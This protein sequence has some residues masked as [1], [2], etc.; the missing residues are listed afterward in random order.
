MRFHYIT[1]LLVAM[2]MLFRRELLGAVQEMLLYPA[3]KISN[4]HLPIRSLL[5]QSLKK[6]ALMAI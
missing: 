5:K 2:P 4:I 6:L 3:K 1:T